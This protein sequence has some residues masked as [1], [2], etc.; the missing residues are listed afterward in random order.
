MIAYRRGYR[1]YHGAISLFFILLGFA[2]QARS[3]ST[4]LHELLEK[5][6]A[7][8]L[9]RDRYWEVLL[10]Y[11]PSL[12]GVE[13]LIDDPH[14]FLSENGKTNPAAELLAT[15]SAF[16]E[17]DAQG[18]AHPQCRFIARYIWIKE[19]LNIDASILPDQICPEW[20]KLIS[21]VRP[22]SATLNFSC[23]FYE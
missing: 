5:A 9:H 22:Q 8:Q 1:F 16:F 23:F 20:D 21:L 17:G 4:S 19:R 13:S 2:A 11:K 14:F 18:D 6:M 7:E 10:H 12:S 3:E 15:I